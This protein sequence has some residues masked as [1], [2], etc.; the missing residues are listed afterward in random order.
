MGIYTPK[1]SPSKLLWGKN[2]ART[3]IQ[4]FYTLL[5]KNLFPQNKFLATPLACMDVE[6]N[7]SVQLRYYNLSV[8]VRI[9]LTVENNNQDGNIRED[10]RILGL[11]R[12]RAQ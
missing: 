1:I 7:Q 5:P 11:H 2:D 4:Q 3:A 10:V 6:S 12:S 9:A 8:I